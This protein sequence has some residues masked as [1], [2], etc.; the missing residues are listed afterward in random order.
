MGGEWVDL[1]DENNRLF[2]RFELSAF[3]VELRVNGRT[4]RFDLLA[5]SRERV[6]VVVRNQADQP[7][8]GE[9]RSLDSD[10]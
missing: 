10:E 6:A 1:R 3:H 8:G 7:S 4:G 5:T 2:G 9:Q